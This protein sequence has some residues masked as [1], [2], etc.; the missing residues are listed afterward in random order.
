MG[1]LLFCMI[2]LQHRL[3]RIFSTNITLFLFQTIIHV[4]SIVASIL[5]FYGFAFVYNTVCINCLGFENP[6]WV[7][8]ELITSVSK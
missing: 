6:F 5:V 7:I 4:L 2:L 3:Q 1:I 8:H